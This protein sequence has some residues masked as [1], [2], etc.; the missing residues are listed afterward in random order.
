ML[1]R[2]SL[3]AICLLTC[4]CTINFSTPIFGG[5][6]TTLN[7]AVLEQGGAA[8]V[9]VIPI[10]G[11]VTSH[12]TRSLFGGEPNMVD[13]V[14]RRLNK[15]RTDSSIAAIILKINSPGGAVSATDTIY[16]E[17]LRFKRARNIPVIAYFQDVAASGGYYIA[18]AAD[19]IVAQPA[20]LC[21]SIGVLSIHVSVEGLMKELGVKAQVLRTGSMKGEGLP[22]ADLTEEQ[23]AHR[24]AMINVAYDGFIGIVKSGR[25]ALKEEDIRKLA[26]GRVYHGQEAL[27]NGLI[28]HVGYFHDAFE[29]AEARAGVSNAT[30]V[31]YTTAI[32]DCERTIYTET[33]AQAPAE[34]PLASQLASKLGLDN[35]GCAM[36]YLWSPE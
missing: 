15:A 5:T 31:T 16:N 18:M 35:T 29:R 22:F 14:M 9:L 2:L 11:T 34:I 30:L 24:Q 6:G 28:D 12:D 32:D 4:A 19:E 20:N 25:P 33:R 27:Q 26:D 10:E 7:E 1:N 17:I 13:T 21:G 23:M 8:K 3:L 36:L